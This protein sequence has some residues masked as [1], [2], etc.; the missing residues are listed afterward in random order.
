MYDKYDYYTEVT[1]APSISILIRINFGFYTK[2]QN[3]ALV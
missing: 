3:E 1:F 2:N